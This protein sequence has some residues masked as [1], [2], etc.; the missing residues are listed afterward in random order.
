[1]F[2]PIRTG[3]SFYTKNLADS[4]LKLGHKVTLVT[5]ENS[6]QQKQ[7]SSY[8]IHRLKAFHFPLKNYFKHLRVCSLYL[9][10]FSKMDEIVKEDKPDIILLVNHYLDIA[11]PT[12]YAARKN[13]IPLVVSV[14]TQLQSLNFFRSKVLNFFD[15]L[16]C[17]YIFSKTQK[18]ISWD[19][20]IERYLKDIH[21][22]KIL[23][24]NTIV[25]FGVNGDLGTYLNH[26][27]DYR[28]VQQIVGVGAIIEQRNFHF[29][30]RIFHEL[31][32]SYPKLKLKIIG[33]IYYQKT[34]FLIKSL[35]LEKKVILTG[36]LPHEK[37]LKELQKS[38]CGWGTL[39]GEYVGLGT[40]NLEAMMMG[41]PVI[42]NIPSDL[43]GQAE[44]IDM[45][46][47]IF[48]DSC[49][50]G[51]ILD[52]MKLILSSHK[53]RRRIGQNGKKLVV[54]YMNWPKVGK[55]MIKVFNQVIKGYRK[56]PKSNSKRKEV[57]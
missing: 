39:T 51:Q 7:S 3:T 49:S 14:G 23:E 54:K 36:E 20:E 47:Y 4:L 2:P 12:I 43:L 25:N 33:H 19:K 16:I 8:K 55:D 26:K 35:K 44:L 5:L 57:K 10:N 30:I 41:V 46:N 31:L 6:N 21:G 1:M 15:K 45:E 52:K 38:V 17:G 9:T 42:S 32:K 29:I 24:K 53:L 27:H 34:V 22:E 37:V 13:K 40:S 48:T 56:D 28:N 11:F 50:T 18:I